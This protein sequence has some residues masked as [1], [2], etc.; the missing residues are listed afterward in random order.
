MV[1]NLSCMSLMLACA[2]VSLLTSSSSN[3]CTRFSR[4]LKRGD[5]SPPSL[6]AAKISAEIEFGW[7]RFK[8]RSISFT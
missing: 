4:Y 7:L 6:L 1:W 2:F 8:I 3:C 5:G